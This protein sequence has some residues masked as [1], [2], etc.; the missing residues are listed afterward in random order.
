MNEYTILGYC[1]QYGQDKELFRFTHNSKS[2]HVS[3]LMKSLNKHKINNALM[4]TTEGIQNVMSLS[5]NYKYANKLEHDNMSTIFVQ[6]D[7]TKPTLQYGGDNIDHIYEQI[8]T[9][10]LFNAADDSNSLIRDLVDNYYGLI[11]YIVSTSN[12]LPEFYTEFFNMLKKPDTSANNQNS[13]FFGKV[14]DHII[15]D[16][17]RLHKL[18]HTNV[19]K[20][21]N[22]LVT[23]FMNYLDN[24]DNLDNLD[25]KIF[26]DNITS[27]IT[28]INEQYT[29][30]KKGERAIKDFVIKD[31]NSI[32]IYFGYM[33]IFRYLY[34]YSTENSKN[35][36]L[37]SKILELGKLFNNKHDSLKI[38]NIKNTFKSVPETN[39]VN[40]YLQQNDVNIN[41]NINV[42]IDGEVE[43]STD[44]KL[45]SLKNQDEYLQHY[46]KLLIYI[47]YEH[48]QFSK[49]KY[50]VT[51]NIQNKINLAK[52]I[53]PTKSITTNNVDLKPQTIN[54]P[55]QL[56][57]LNQLNYNK[58]N[59][60]KKVLT[61]KKNKA[62]AE[63]DGAA[64]GDNL[65]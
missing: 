63:G 19:E 26:K 38:K 51:Q 56:N 33:L 16:V 43:S 40:T 48:K 62:A 27:I 1:S 55:N 42:D 34:L 13:I 54:Q 41:V 59:M 44:N 12:E 10:S 36:D 18:N 2:K 46:M 49:T 3:N 52:K 65:T 15:E 39:N 64:E 6:Y 31:F 7:N 17:K 60:M 20:P 30:A 25:E 32:Q 4:E 5:H 47:A 22:S 58:S 14:Y 35:V 28:S 21:H 9:K 8:N 61:W 37:C 23:E 24:L 45:L 50:V 11:N 29:E 53:N 57:K